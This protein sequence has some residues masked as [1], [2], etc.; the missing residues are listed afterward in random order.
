M[1]DPLVD[2]AKLTMTA[3]P[4]A[5]AVVTVGVA[6]TTG[7]GVGVGAGVGTDVD[8]PPPP[9]PQINAPDKIIIANISEPAC[10]GTLLTVGA[11]L[12]R[13]SAANHENTS[14]TQKS[15]D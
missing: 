1:V 4:S 6:A 7:V 10:I 13:L 5:G 11:G 9:H 8:P 15:I 12:E 2:D 3:P 14:E